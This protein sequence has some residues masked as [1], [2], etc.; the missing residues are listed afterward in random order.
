M[1]IQGESDSNFCSILNVTFVSGESCLVLDG[2]A[3]TH[4]IFSI[5]LDGSICKLSVLSV[6]L[7]GKDMRVNVSNVIISNSQSS[8][9][10]NFTKSITT[11]HGHCQFYHNKGVIISI[12]RNTIYFYGVKVEFIS[13]S[14]FRGSVIVAVESS[15][16]FSNSH[17]ILFANNWGQLC[18][19]I[20][21]TM[22]SKMTL[23]EQVNIDFIGNRGEQGGAISLYSKS[24]LEFSD[25]EALNSS[26]HFCSNA[27][28]KGGA[29]FIDDSTCIHLYLSIIT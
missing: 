27:A 1:F 16:T 13:N 6:P 7:S 14:A 5:H 29:I 26:L 12:Y 25:R 15:I 10:M 23:K 22:E 11:F 9:V 3:N 28:L 19:G 17:I 8:V 21:L 20:T 24:V 2:Q 4:T 18:G